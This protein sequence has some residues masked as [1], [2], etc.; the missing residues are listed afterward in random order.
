MTRTDTP[1]PTA[2]ASA[3]LR[4]FEEAVHER[5]FAGAQMPEA[6]EEIEAEYEAA[7]AR[8]RRHLKQ[9]D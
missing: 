3:A 9:K 4:R 1:R 5:A 2:A 8:V 7:K 6:R